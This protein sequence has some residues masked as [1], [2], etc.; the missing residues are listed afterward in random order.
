MNAPPAAVPDPIRIPLVPGRPGFEDF[1]SAWLIP[2]PPVCVVDP[3]PAATADQLF[4][5]LAAHGVAGIDFL[6][7]THIHLDH[8]GG[9]G[10][11]A[12]RFPEAR[13]VCHPKAVAHLADP[14][15]LWEGSRKVLGSLA[16][17]YGPVEAVPPDRLLAAD[18]FEEEGITALLTPGHAAHHVSFAVGELLFAGEAC[19]VVYDLG[20]SGLYMRPATPAVF[21]LEQALA[22]LDLLLA[23]RPGRMV[24]GH[25]GL[26]ADGASLLRRHRLQLGDWERRISGLAGR[27]LEEIAGELLARDP[28]LAAFSAFPAAAQER[29][30]YFLKNSLNGFLGWVVSRRP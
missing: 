14:T 12:R 2:G 3:G 29:E 16:D 5:A 1:L 4:A 10:R 20:G 30:R 26:Y 24:V 6:L 22:S 28:L 15:R 13:V 23:R 17:L 21:D 18:R 11:I 8:A 25:S 7:L 9:V 19:G 27:A